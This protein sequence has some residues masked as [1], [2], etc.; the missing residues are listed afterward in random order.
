MALQLFKIADVTVATPQSSVEFSSIPSG[1]TDLYLVISARTDASEVDRLINLT[2]NNSTS[3]YS[4]RELLANPTTVTSLSWSSASQIYLFQMAASGATSNTFGSISTYIPNY[5]S[6][7]YKSVSC[8]GVTETNATAG[9]NRL[10]SLSAS[11]WSNTAAIT[12][13]KFT[14][15]AGNFVANS[16]FTLYGIL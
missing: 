10:L 7:N 14:P 11:L 12:S 16:T 15:Q 8:D 6:S 4:T 13:M 5:T 3:G 2:F 9:T 1:Y